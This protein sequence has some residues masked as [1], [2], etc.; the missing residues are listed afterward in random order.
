MPTVPQAANHRSSARA[1][2]AVACCAVLAATAPAGTFALF[3]GTRGHSPSLLH[4]AHFSPAVAPVVSHVRVRN[5]IT[6]TWQAVTI[7]SGATVLYRVMRIPVTGSPQ[8]VCT[9]VSA[10]VT[11]GTT[12]SCT[13]A[14]PGANS[15][16]TYTEQPYVA[17]Q[18]QMTWSL[19]ASTPA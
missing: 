12:V 1:F 5:Q 14:I 15:N 3:S 19:P 11:T 13:A 7:S 10:P 2:R 6:L 9:G 8:E 17:Y 4:G 18:G 16:D